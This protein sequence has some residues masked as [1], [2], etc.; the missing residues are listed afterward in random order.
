MRDIAELTNEQAWQ[1]IASLQH[2]H[3]LGQQYTLGG[4]ALTHPKAGT[5]L[6]SHWDHKQDLTSLLGW[7]QVAGLER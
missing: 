6:M 2:K 3:Q 5:F 4:V 7:L 1:R